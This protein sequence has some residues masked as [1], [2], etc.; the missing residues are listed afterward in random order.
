MRTSKYSL[1][2]LRL[3]ALLTLILCAVLLPAAAVSANGDTVG[4]VIDPTPKTITVGDTFSV[5]I[6]VTISA[7]EAVNT[8]EAHI[9]FDPT[10]L[11]VVSIAAGTALPNV[12]WNQHD[13]TAGTIDYVAGAQLGGAAP[14]TD[15]VLATLNLEAKAATQATPLTF[16]FKKPIRNTAT[17][18]LVDENVED[19]LDPGAVIDGRVQILPLGSLNGHVDLQGR[20]T[21]P[22]ASWITPLTVV[23]FEQG[24]STVVRTEEVTT[25]N[26]GNFT[27]AD[28]ETGTYDIGV[29]C[30]RSLSELVTGVAFSA[31]TVTPVT[32]GTLRE[33][34]AN[35]DDVITGADYSVLWSYLGQTSGEALDKCDFNRD[36][37]VS[38]IDYSLLWMNLGQVGD[39][40]GM[41]P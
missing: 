13:D 38:A 20:P 9:N 12:L 22:D 28:V 21:P 7:G 41:W 27:V 24:T 14:T 23:L 33:G 8:A 15:F 10:Y 3:A 40:Q 31:D 11:E 25:D 39:M 6:K 5:D 34:D 2:L 36:G 35:N 18:A 4:M 26:E 29:K 17:Y 30:P 37:V 1:G 19:V 16:V 32:F